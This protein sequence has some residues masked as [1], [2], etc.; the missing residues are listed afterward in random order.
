MVDLLSLQQLNVDECCITTDSEA[1]PGWNWRNDCSETTFQYWQYTFTEISLAPGQ[2]YRM[3]SRTV[4]S[5]VMKHD[6][7]IHILFNTSPAKSQATLQASLSRT[8]LQTLPE[9]LSPLKGHSISTQLS[10][11]T[12]SALQK[13]LV[14]IRNCESRI[15]LKHVHKHEACLPRGKKI[16]SVSIQMILFLFVKA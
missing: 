5:Q 15:A 3:Y 7:T 9:L 1:I 12:V 4:V 8:F 6:A 14:L 10:S 16:S 2:L 13:V 11:D